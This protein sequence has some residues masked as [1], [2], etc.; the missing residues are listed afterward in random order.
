M[1]GK[2]DVVDDRVS[3]ESFHQTSCFKHRHRLPEMEGPET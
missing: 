3:M 2:A 1:D